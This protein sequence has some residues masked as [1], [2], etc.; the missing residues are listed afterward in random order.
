MIDSLGF[1]LA[2]LSAHEQKI[3]TVAHNV[4]NVNTEGFKKDRV[5]I[6]SNEFGQPG[7]DTSG[8]NTP[9]Y[10]VQGP[11]AEVEISNVDV[12]EETVD[13]TL[14]KTGLIANLKVIKSTVDTLDSILDIMA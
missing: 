4:A 3:S 9:G 14:G 2:G 8:V 12:A 11:D 7:A 10:T 1:G 5:T 6:H 13:L